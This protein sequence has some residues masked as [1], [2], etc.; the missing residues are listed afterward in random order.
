MAA[1]LAVKSDTL[2]RLGQHLTRHPPDA[3]KFKA[4]LN[5]GAQQRRP[6]LLSAAQ[7][8]VGAK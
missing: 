8:M 3:F 2:Q 5:S 1:I 6:V 4:I 7:Q